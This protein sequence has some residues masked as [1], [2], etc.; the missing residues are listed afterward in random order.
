MFRPV[1]RKKNEIPAEAAKALLHSE[2]R[3]VLAVHGDDG[4]PYAVPVNYFYDEAAGTILIHGSPRGHKADAIRQDSKVCFT[5]YGNETTDSE[6]PWAPRLQSAVVFGRCRIVE[7]REEILALCR[8]L[9]LKYY[10]DAASVDAELAHSG[11]AVAMYE[12]T[13]EHLSG[14]QIQES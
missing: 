5:V 3:G 11:Q 2:R 13:V 9:A 10:P 4:Y 1:R 14:K 12:I 8:K 7:S 6:L